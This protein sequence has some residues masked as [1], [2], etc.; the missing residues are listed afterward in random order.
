MGASPATHPVSHQQPKAASRWLRRL[1]DGKLSRLCALFSPYTANE[2]DAARFR[3]RQ[4]QAILRLTPV[5]ATVNVANVIVVLVVLWSRAPH[6]FLLP[7][8]GTIVAFA[9]LGF[10]GW[11]RGRRRTIGVASPRALRSMVWQAAL[12]AAVWG[13]LPAVLLGRVDA[14]GQFFIGMTTVGMICGGGFVLASVPL[15]GSTWPVVQGLGALVGL[16]ASA[17]PNTAGMVALLGLYVLTVVFSVIQTARTFGAQLMA[18]ARADHQHEVIG[19]LLRDYEDHASDLLWELDAAG[20]FVHASQRLRDQLGVTGERLQEASAAELLGALVPPNVEARRAW[21]TLRV[22]LGRSGSLRDDIVALRMGGET[23]WWAI[24]ARRLDGPGG[25]LLGWRGVASDHTDK[26]L[27]HRRLAWLAHNDALTGLV[28]RAQFRDL[29]Q[30]A[31]DTDAVDAAPL[32]VVYADLDG[33]KQV[34][35]EHGHAAGDELLRTAGER[36]LAAAR[37]TDVVA[38]L[39]GDEFAM[40]LRGVRD[41]AEAQ[42]LVDRALRLLDAPVIVGDRAVRLRASLGVALAPLHGRDLDTLMNR[43]DLALYTAKNGG[44]QRSCV[45]DESLVERNRRR[46]Q[47]EDALRDA[48]ARGELHLKFQPQLDSTTWRLVGFEALLRWT[49]PTLGRV[50]PSEFVPIAE[51]LGLMPTIGS[52]VIAEACRAA[53]SWTRDLSVSIN[54]SPLQLADPRFVSNLLDATR[55]LDHRRI[56]LEVTESALLDDVARTLALLATLR[57]H[58]FRI[59][60]D[61]FGTGYSALSYLRRFSFDVLK[62]DRGFVRDLTKNPEARVLVETILA[63]AR[64]LGMSTVAEGV[65][66][67]EEAALLRARGCTVLQGYYVSRPMQ[68]TSV[69][70]FARSWTSMTPAMSLDAIPDVLTMAPPAVAE[71]AAAERAAARP[72]DADGATVAGDEP[73]DV[74]VGSDAARSSVGATAD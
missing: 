22:R 23:R 60:L 66:T 30:A 5:A 35:D 64:S 9:L 25:A 54:V 18:E 7:W 10:R 57:A 8:A 11:V 43:A 16:L 49:H 24:S 3:A 50:A 53:A 41:A 44:G 61:D 39:G 17:M 45:F 51:S 15:A 1:C 28:N 72:A 47:L 6:A 36:L 67:E 34:N 38:R 58:G 42:G 31:L 29:L 48:I 21:R 12:F 27:A 73:D 20:R 33:F 70:A 59:A 56:T 14:T 4:I 26:H 74:L 55:D 52:W 37:R 63:M 46:T 32:A 19:L 62:I 68:P 40:L 2:A 65:E 71:V 13:L 69:T